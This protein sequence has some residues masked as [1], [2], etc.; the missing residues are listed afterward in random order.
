MVAVSDSDSSVHFRCYDS[1][2]IIKRTRYHLSIENIA[3]QVYVLSSR[4]ILFGTKI[5][6]LEEKDISTL[7]NVSIVQKGY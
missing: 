4:M 1:S 2:S 3:D 7:L 6:Y 5:T